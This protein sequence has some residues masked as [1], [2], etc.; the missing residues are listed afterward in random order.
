MAGPRSGIAFLY[1]RAAFGVRPAEL[2][3][4][5]GKGYAASV[6]AILGASRKT[7]VRL[8]PPP[9]FKP[10]PTTVPADPVARAEFARRV[11]DE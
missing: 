5:V 4:Q 10:L 9:N 2:D 1:R 6:D 8:E 3:A 11:R 7:K